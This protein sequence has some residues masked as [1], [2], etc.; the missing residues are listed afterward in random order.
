MGNASNSNKHNFL[1][2]GLVGAGKSLLV[3]LMDPDSKFQSF[4]DEFDDDI[5]VSNVGM[6]GIAYYCY[7]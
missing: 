4:V 1:V 3:T 2:M 5:N 6:C 7:I